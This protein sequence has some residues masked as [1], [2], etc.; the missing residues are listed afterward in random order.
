VVTKDDVSQ[1]RA[2]KFELFRRVMEQ[3]PHLAELVRYICP[4]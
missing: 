3:K 4:A 1:S 2:G